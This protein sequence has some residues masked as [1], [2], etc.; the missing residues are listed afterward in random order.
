MRACCGCGLGSRAGARIRWCGNSLGLGSLPAG[1]GPSGPRQGPG[2]SSGPQ[3]APQPRAWP[4]VSWLRPSPRARGASSSRGGSCLC[5]CRGHGP[6]VSTL[7]HGAD[8]GTSRETAAASPKSLHRKGERTPQSRLSAQPCLPCVRASRRRAAQKPP[9]PP[10]ACSA[11]SAGLSASRPSLTRS[12][13]S[14]PA[15]PPAARLS[16]LDW[17]QSPGR[18]SDAPAA[19]NSVNRFAQGIRYALKEFRPRG[20]EGP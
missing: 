19:S 9:V 13:C 15:Q 1:A 11:G 3:Q 16:P 8:R 7:A 10:A 2:G 4:R 17:R 20:W 5:I 6:G 14:R 12:Q 18:P